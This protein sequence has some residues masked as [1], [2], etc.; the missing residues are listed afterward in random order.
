MSVQRR[1]L[2][3]FENTSMMITQQYTLI[4]IT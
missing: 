4:M 2:T 1:R 3:L